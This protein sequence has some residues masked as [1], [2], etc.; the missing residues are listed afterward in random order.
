[1]AA[2][3]DELEKSA[4][5]LA[6]WS[7]RSSAFEELRVY[8]DGGPRPIPVMSLLPEHR[9]GAWEPTRI[10]WLDL[11]TH[12][13]ILDAVGENGRRVLLRYAAV[14]WKHELKPGRAADTTQR[15]LATWGV[16]LV[17]AFRA[18]SREVPG[19]VLGRL[20]NPFVE[21]DVER[22]VR[23]GF[24]PLIA[25]HPST[26]HTPDEVLRRFPHA[27][28][29]SLVHVVGSVLRWLWR[30][31]PR[32]DAFELSRVIT[33][34]VAPAPRDRYTLDELE[35]AFVAVGGD[36]ATVRKGMRLS[37]WISYEAGLGM[38]ALGRV[39][40]AL[41]WLEEAVKLGGGSSARWARDRAHMLIE[42][43]RKEWT[44]AVAGSRT[45]VIAPINPWQTVVGSALRHES[46]GEYHKALNLYQNIT[47]GTAPGNAL[48]LALAR[49]YL[50]LGNTT[51]AVE[52]ARDAQL[53]EPRRIAFL[54]EMRALLAAKQFEHA[55]ARFNAIAPT[56]D[57]A[58][59]EYARGKCL[60]G[61]GR[62]ADARGTFERVLRLKPGMAAALLMLREVE[63][64]TR[65][66]RA[67]AG[68]GDVPPA[69]TPKHLDAVHA[70]LIGGRTGDAIDELARESYARDAVAQLMRADLLLAEQQP[71]RALAV[72]LQAS[73]LGADT[74]PAAIVGTGLAL[75]ALDRA[76]EA[77]EM[78]DHVPE[79]LDALE[80][81]AR[82]LD[83]LGR[84]D[85]A[86]A[87]RKRHA[88]ACATRSDL[89]LRTR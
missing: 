66:T 39:D 84:T 30:D 78:F 32:A 13:N 34:A 3:E 72:Y 59:I 77:L 47:P 12:P 26:R 21:V 23:I 52:R 57:D 74:R 10:V 70:M 86:E 53:H 41:E 25:G 5:E 37:A 1:M 79:S 16:Q 6:H 29:R 54:I 64:V 88:D 63:R 19:D 61:L 65:T 48:T 14:H 68:T 82:A 87:A 31:L 28:E 15:R 18:I 67:A 43:G 45:T 62:L 58:D 83:A 81:R 73:Q 49:C 33:R 7:L 22:Q 4:L 51:L 46:R 24:L 76:E 80:G 9:R 56:S 36:A 11:P 69:P 27:D 2:V 85:E 38:L 35:A 20:T 75:L 40:A 44:E 89:R 71:D 8:D 55:I 60:L 42:T 50:A 17:D